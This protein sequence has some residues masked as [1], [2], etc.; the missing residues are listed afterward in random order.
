MSRKILTIDAEQMII[1]AMERVF[2]DCDYEMAGAVTPGEA[3]TVLATQPVDL[4][5]VDLMMY[6]F[7]GPDLLL[8]V[9][10][11]NP[12]AGRI[13]LS[14]LA[15]SRLLLR[16][17]AQ[18]AA[19]LYISKPWD[20]T[21]LRAKVERI[22]RLQDEM[23]MF[24]ATRSV[25]ALERL[26][27]TAAAYARFDALA[28]GERTM[29]NLYRVIGGSVALTARVMH[30]GNVVFGA[31]AVGSL[32]R[33]L[34]AIGYDNLR[35]ILG[36]PESRPAAVLTRSQCDDLAMRERHS[37]CRVKAFE[38]LYRGIKAAE[39]PDEWR[40]A[41]L[42]CDAG[43][44]LILQAD[45]ARFRMCRGEAQAGSFPRGPEITPCQAGALLLEWWQCPPEIFQTARDCVGPRIDAVEKQRIEL[46]AMIH[47]ADVFAW[48]SVEGYTNARIDAAVAELLQRDQDALFRAMS[49]AGAMS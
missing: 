9:R 17:V 45:H 42:L 12:L 28:E 40:T 20:N 6:P 36:V 4:V 43:W 46:I 47:A 26:P 39:P 33:M 25:P 34:E 29:D 7:D 41:A 49:R 10:E 19:H 13:L 32:R 14:A 8:T 37:A 30:V 18:G 1:N 24:A 44:Y 35:E 38:A 3:V 31:G 11:S 21:L 27:A 15:D 23:G 5:I 2:I 16:T 22:F 48:H